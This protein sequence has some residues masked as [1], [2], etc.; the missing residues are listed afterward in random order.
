MVIK[1]NNSHG[2]DVQTKVRWVLAVLLD[3]AEGILNDPRK[4]KPMVCRWND[5]KMLSVNDARVRLISSQTAK[6]RTSL[7]DEDV[8]RAFGD[9]E[10]LGIWNDRRESK[11]QGVGFW[12]FD[13]SFGTVERTMILAEFDRLWKEKWNSEKTGPITKLKSGMKPGAPLQEMPLP[14]N[15]VARPDALDAVKRKLLA[16][17]EQALVVSAIAGLGGLGKSVLAA[18]IVLDI[19]VQ[20]R[21]ED[22]ILWVTLGQKPDLLNCLCDLIHELEKSFSPN[23]LE[24]ASRYLGT[25]LTA[26]RMLLVVDDVW[27]KDDAKWFQVGGRGCR[28]L[29]TTRKE[30]IKGADCYPLDLMSKQEVIELVQRKL[31]K[32]WRSSDETSFLVFAKSLGY[33][34]LALDLAANLVRDDGISWEELREEFESERRD[35]ALRLLDSTTE[36]WEQFSEEKQRKYS[37]QACFNLSL[38]RLNELQRSQ[39][40]WLGVLQEDVS[41]TVAVGKVLWALSTVQTKRVLK[42]LRS[43]SLLMN[44]AETFEGERTYRV[45]DLM[46]D[47]A[48]GLIEVGKIEGVK[49]LEGAHRSFLNRYRRLGA[50]N[51]LPI[52]DIYIFRHL[53]WHLEQ[54]NL[55][56]EVHDLL[57]MSDEHGRNAWFEACD[58]IGQPAIFVKSIADSWRLAEELYETENERAI[59]LQY[60]YDA[61][62]G[63]NFG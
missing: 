54:A 60:R 9:L 36:D 39:F 38:I 25:L 33:L 41:L 40:N 19:E 16:E 3:Y 24:S 28:V 55:I 61:C 14:D 12:Q 18:A 53:T 57:A 1:R 6:Q 4:S 62:L 46:H 63:V 7:T 35:V 27:N 34:P 47:M 26:R 5:Q 20:S 50:W 52:E 58:R 30:E 43:R 32:K 11:T 29:I 44:G 45:H 2:K 15:F 22:G 37:L 49:D 31:G 21:F 23:T 17:S 42:E 59:V 10:E 13:L 48:R 8:K 56:D 51:E